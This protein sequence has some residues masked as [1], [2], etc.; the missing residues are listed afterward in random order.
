MYH[1]HS[2]PK[3]SEWSLH[4]TKGQ[5]GPVFFP[6]KDIYGGKYPACWLSMIW[7]WVTRECHTSKPSSSY[8]PC[9]E[10]SHYKLKKLLQSFINPSIPI[11]SHRRN[12]LPFGDPT[13]LRN[14]SF[15]DDSPIKMPVYKGRFNPNLSQWIPI[16]FL[17]I[18]MVTSC[19]VLV[20]FNMA[21][22]AV[23]YHRTIAMEYGNV[24]LPTR[25]G[26]AR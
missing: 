19:H 15:I 2:R 1:W 25:N 14:P 26:H 23:N 4:L 8:I 16:E 22:P 21:Y 24:Y 11:P 20:G 9:R 12:T 7:G 17:P 18:W 5:Q 3:R 13:L 6:P 10:S